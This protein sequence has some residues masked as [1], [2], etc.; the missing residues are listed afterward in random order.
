MF[1]KND[2]EW[3]RNDQ[4]AEFGKQKEEE[5]FQVNFEPRKKKTWTEA[6]MLTQNTSAHRATFSIIQ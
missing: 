2:W 6:L 4:F 3:K 5:K 1:L